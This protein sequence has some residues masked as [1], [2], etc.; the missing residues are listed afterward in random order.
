MELPTIV[1]TADIRVPD[2]DCS[3]TYCLSAL[4]TLFCVEKTVSEFSVT[5]KVTCG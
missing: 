4:V 5:V 3:F 1:L 2:V